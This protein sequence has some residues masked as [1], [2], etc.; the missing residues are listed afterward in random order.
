MTSILD[1]VTDEDCVT[2]YARRFAEIIL[3]KADTRALNI[4]ADYGEYSLAGGYTPKRFIV[5]LTAALPLIT[6]SLWVNAIED[7]ENFYR[8][9]KA[10]ELLSGK[11]AVLVYQ[12]REYGWSGD[13][14]K[15]PTALD[16]VLTCFE[17]EPLDGI[18]LRDL[19][20]GGGQ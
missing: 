4:I 14:E 10:R 15:L 3:A 18:D 16:S 20:L 5:Y 19:D 13:T 6:V 17:D 11:V 9:E 12:A 1:F 8:V 2:L 7:L